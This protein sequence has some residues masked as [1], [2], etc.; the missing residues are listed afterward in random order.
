MVGSDTIEKEGLMMK[1]RLFISILALAS[2]AL[3]CQMANSFTGDTPV[4]SQGESQ[5]QTERL[6]FQDD[7][8]SPNSGWDR[9]HNEDGV[10]DYQDGQYRILV[11]TTNT[12]VWANPGLNFT[13]TIIE[14]DTTKVGGDNNNDFGVVCR[15]KDGENFY[16]FVISSDG[17]YGI[18]KVKD[19]QQVLVGMES[20]PPTDAVK[21][22]NAT[23]RIQ[24]DCDGS[25]LRLTVNGELLAQTTD[26]DLSSGDVGLLAGSFHNPGTDILFDNFVVR[27]P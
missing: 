23:N 9:L 7:F 24:A 16:F 19:G 17:Y 27:E 21:Q 26:E 22:G 11:N 5:D 3:G 4:E 6:L 1:L 8:S 25:T 15:Y 13:N 14:V 2:T 20:M 10:T 12:D 18:G